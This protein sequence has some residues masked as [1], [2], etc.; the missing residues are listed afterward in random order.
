MQQI[1]PTTLPIKLGTEHELFNITK[2]WFKAFRIIWCL[3]S[4]IIGLLISKYIIYD[5]C[6][7]NEHCNNVAV[8]FFSILA[9]AS[10]IN[11]GISIDKLNTIIPIA[12]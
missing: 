6:L 2:N 4:F 11:S 9:T 12:S 10:F 5:Q 1:P 7:L 3:G 8:T